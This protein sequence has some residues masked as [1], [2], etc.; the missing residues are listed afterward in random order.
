MLH[1]KAMI[2]FLDSVDLAAELISF[3][4]IK[5]SVLS[6]KES[7]LLLKVDFT[8]ENSKQIVQTE[9]QIN[10]KGMEKL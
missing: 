6:V 8:N 9:I 1:C 2:L 10:I 7:S 4:K 3:V 5:A